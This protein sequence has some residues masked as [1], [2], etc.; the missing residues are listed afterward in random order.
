MEQVGVNSIKPIVLKAKVSGNFREIMFHVALFC[1]LLR[2]ARL[3][4]TKKKNRWN[5]AGFQRFS[6]VRY[7]GRSRTR[8]YDLHDVN[9]AL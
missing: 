9:V 1:A 8:I 4:L 6:L 5:L 3:G 7:G 2:D